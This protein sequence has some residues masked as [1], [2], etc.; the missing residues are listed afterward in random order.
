MSYPTECQLRV[1]WVGS[2]CLRAVLR[3]GSHESVHLDKT[4][5]LSLRIPVLACEKSLASTC[6]ACR[7]YVCW[8]AI[9]H[10]VELSRMRVAAGGT[11]PRYLATL[12]RCS[13]PGPAT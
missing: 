8:I 4:G 13:S 1:S 7:A 12:L 10:G 11:A 2:L 5:A 6:G 3:P 9:L